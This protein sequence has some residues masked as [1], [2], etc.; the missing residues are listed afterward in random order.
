MKFH[1]PLSGEDSVRYA[2]LVEQGTS[3]T[4]HAD[5][6]EWLQGDIQQ[7][8]PHDILLAGWGNFQEG[9]IQH[10]VVSRLPGARSYAAGTDGLPF[11][12][13]KFHERWLAAGRQPCSL[14]FG[15]FEYLLGQASLPGSFSSSL[16]GMRSVLIHGLHDERAQQEC[17][18]VL[19]SADGIPAEPAGTAIRLLMPSMDAALRQ[20][21]PLPQQRRQAASP[22]LAVRGAADDA[23]GL[24]ER[25]TQIMAWVAM[26]KTNSEIG[27]ILNISGFTVKN[28]MQRIFQKLNVFNRAQAVSKVT[29]V[30]VYG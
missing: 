8:L 24:S 25:E 3:I 14:D 21:P 29:K 20:M 28:H 13:G 26:G 17:L 2:A 19:M 30:T 7:C 10:D 15:E 23:S 6:L 4:R 1:T 18:Y 22:A 11:L 16:R 9:A 12:L 5:L 27:A